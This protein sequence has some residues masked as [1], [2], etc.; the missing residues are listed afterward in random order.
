MTDPT[1]ETTIA[2]GPDGAR[3]AV[4]AVHGVADQAPN[5]TARSVA[6]LLLGV[7]QAPQGTVAYGRF[8]ETP[9]RIEVRRLEP[10][11]EAE[12]EHDEDR[13]PAPPEP[14]EPP[15]GSEGAAPLE[16]PRAD[17]QREI[18]GSEFAAHLERRHTRRARKTAALDPTAEAAPAPARDEVDE[19][20]ID[21]QFTSMQIAR[22]EATLD[23]PSYDTLCLSAER[24]APGARGRT[25]VDVYEM[26]WADLSRLGS[27]LLR[28]AG[29]LYQLF[30]H[31]SSLGRNTVDL[32]ADAN[33]GKP[34]WRALRLL[35]RCCNWTLSVPIGLLNMY[36]PILVLLLALALVPAD[37][38]AICAA[39]VWALLGMLAGSALMYR[40]SWQPIRVWWPFPGWL[41]VQIAG[42]AI[43]WKLGS[44]L[45]L[46]PAHW[47]V[48]GALLIAFVV[49]HWLSVKYDNSRPGALR[50]SRVIML[51]LFVTFAITA[52]A[53]GG[54]PAI[55]GW[56][57]RQVEIVFFT[58]VM[59]WTLLIPLQILS[60]CAGER[61]LWR[62]A[63]DASINPESPRQ[64]ARRVVWTGRLG[65]ALS[66]S[67]F[68]VVTLSA[69]AVVLFVLP[70]QKFSKGLV[71]MTYVPSIHWLGHDPTSL[72][73]YAGTL[74]NQSGGPLFNAF[75]VCVLLSLLMLLWA[76]LPSVV[77]EIAP[78]R[79]AER[80]ASRRLGF[81][82]DHGFRLARLAG[83]VLVFGLLVV[84]TTGFILK[85]RTG[86]EI[87]A[88]LDGASLGWLY[89]SIK[90]LIGDSNLWIYAGMLL[91][92]TTLGVVALG[93]RLGKVSAGLR[94]ILD[95]ALDVDNWL[96]ENPLTHNPKS[97]ILAR[98]S[99][100]LRHI[101][102]RRE[103]G[104][105]HYD[106]VVIVAHSQ[107]T[108]ITADLL[109][110]LHAQP[111]R[112]PF[113]GDVP[114]FL[115]TMG[116]P[117]R[118]LYGLRFPHLYAWA[119]YELP[120]DAARLTHLEGAIPAARKPL[121]GE[122]G[123]AL[124][125]NAYRSGDYVG[126][127]LWIRDDDP[128]RWDPAT[129][130][131]DSVASDAPANAVAEAKRIEFCIGAG[132]HTHYFDQTAARVGEAIDQ[133][134]SIAAVGKANY[135]SGYPVFS[136]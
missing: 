40:K 130:A 108:V 72:G 107:G 24:V 27:G 132:A 39:A 45:V 92:G 99:S 33:S 34:V 114:L 60:W 90:G 57:M 65:F 122:L 81:W 63:S 8:V 71:S 66:S 56:I 106:A 131:G 123:V 74:L 64:L 1:S 54:A 49:A 134:I 135:P 102:A 25:Q 87:Q 44:G 58:L 52:P 126:R 38:L 117:L 101:G 19:P 53:D 88:F 5:E 17:E 133:L 51:V 127:R 86:S 78:P 128:A 59:L 36:L 118:Q 120:P 26:Y 42:L 18:L 115:L 109:R 75:F 32:G 104:K 61:V 67:L 98:Y 35:Q 112:W 95:I 43:G 73:A 12:P 97:R 48:G 83:S 62:A 47:L 69:W 77:A 121:P 29:E 11:R 105:R 70:T 23:S 16:A 15:K 9:L 91:G 2:G 119:R 50:L 6:D 4:I 85:D 96:R 80:A 82:L 13:R 129:P 94:P 103:S 28:I 37:S 14:P 93:S 3:I 111:E 89:T 100:L 22:Y 84:L 113:D 20:A 110:Y 79:N 30:F 55:A 125:V 31:L 7:R 68:M 41:A 21:L 136:N 76:A 124:W 116:C 10:R 46:L